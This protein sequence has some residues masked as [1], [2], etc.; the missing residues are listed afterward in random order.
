MVCLSCSRHQNVKRDKCLVAVIL[1]EIS[2]R[3]GWVQ[4]EPFNVT[5]AM[6]WFPIAVFFCAMLLSSFLSYQYMNVPMVS[7]LSFF[8]FGR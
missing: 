7:V 6:R 8:V 5:T 3:M 2:R 1:V 4:Y